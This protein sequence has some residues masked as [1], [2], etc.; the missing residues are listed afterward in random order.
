MQPLQTSS[1]KVRLGGISLRSSWSRGQGVFGGGGG[2][3]PI[4]FRRFGCLWKLLARWLRCRV[5][6][7]GKLTVLDSELLQRPS[8]AVDNLPPG[9]AKRGSLGVPM[10]GDDIS[11]KPVYTA[12][13]TRVTHVVNFKLVWVGFYTL[14]VIQDRSRW[15]VCQGNTS[16]HKPLIS[17][18]AQAMLRRPADQGSNSDFEPMIDRLSCRILRFK[19]AASIEFHDGEWMDVDKNG[20]QTLLL[21]SEACG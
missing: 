16:Q 5:V 17:L 11:L 20:F 10:P 2:E 3:G 21:F 19:N 4:S 12:A 1:W 15:T 6:D 18:C 14:E 13:Y 9:L 7:V 8:W